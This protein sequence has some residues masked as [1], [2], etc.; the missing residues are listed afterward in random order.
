MTMKKNKNVPAIRFKGFTEGWKEKEFS[1][2]FLPLNNNT[3]SRAELN[4]ESGSTKNVH[5]GDVLIKF[6]EC[7]D[8]SKEELPYITNEKI[9]EKYT[10]LRDGDI[11]FA[12]AA[13]DE[14]VGKCTELLNVLNERIV[15]GLHTIACRPLFTF[16]DGYLGCFLNAPI[17]HNQLL[18]LMQGTKVVGIS[19]TAIKDTII[20]YP[21]FT[22]QQ[23]IGNYFQNIDKLI[24]ANQSKLDKLKNIKKA[25]LEKMFP[26]KGATTPEIRFKG[27]SGEWE[28]K[29]VEELLVERNI[30]APKNENYPLMAFIAY[31]GVAPKGDRYNREFLVS[32]EANKKYKRT[33]LG[34]FIYSSNNLE[35]GSIGL[36]KYGGASISPV[37]SIFMP[38][39]LANSDFIGRL[40]IRKDFINKMVRWR[41]GVIYGQWRIH[42]SDFIQIEVYVPSVDE[43]KPIGTFFKKLDNL[44]SKNEQ[45][46]TK[47]KNIKKA[48]LEKMFVNKEDVL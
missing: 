47:L 3:L 40:L 48:C 11:V 45:Q 35:T 8:V 42:E 34:D 22:E 16:A 9:V 4:Y 13:E 29:K 38:T 25:C 5:Y 32:D 28:E 17:Y 30:Q 26:K 23:Q 18:P 46:L 37:Y 12:D 14:T 15:S 41:Q 20:Y 2:T 24:E 1:N 27:F 36:N 43:Q 44:I 19:K 39:Y 6:G 31:E 10:S 7:L 21:D 33:E